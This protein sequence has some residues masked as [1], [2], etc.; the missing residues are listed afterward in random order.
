MPKDNSP[1]DKKPRRSRALAVIEAPAER[2]LWLRMLLHSPKDMVAGLIAFAAVS[3]IIGNAIFLQAGR[4]P[5]P[6]FGSSV[7][8]PLPAP[9]ASVNLLPKPR[10]A[11]ATLR[12]GEAKLDSRMLDARPVDGKP[13]TK[14]DSKPVESRAAAADPMAGLV[15]STTHPPANSTAVARP[16][17]PIPNAAR[18]PLG[19]LIVNSRRVAS[20]QRALTEY[21]YGQLKPTGTVGSDTQA[22]IQRFER[23]R[24]LPVTGQVSDRMVRELATVTGRPIE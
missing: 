3:A 10:P 19:D 1:K 13:E 23:E 2:S 12:P 8:V 9:S 21:G 20:V 18:D 14:A 11:D 17:A 4:H 6:M 22:A 15:K 7:V 16:P 5:S 24:K